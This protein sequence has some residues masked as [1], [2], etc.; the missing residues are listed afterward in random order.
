VLAGVEA[1]HDSVVQ[2]G[3]KPGGGLASFGP[4]IRLPAAE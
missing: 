3:M 4:E 2:A 1:V